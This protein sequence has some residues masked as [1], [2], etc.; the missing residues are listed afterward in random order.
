MIRRPPRSTQGVSSA[1]SDVYKRQQLA[2][3]GYDVEVRFLVDT[4]ID[5]AVSFKKRWGFKEAEIVTDHREI[6]GKVDAALIFTPHAFH[7]GQCLDFL[8]SEAHVLVEKPMVC[9]LEHAY[10]LVE[11]SKSKGLVLEVGYQRHFE[12]PFIGLRETLLKEELGKVNIISMILG[13]DWYLGTK[14]T[15]RQVRDCLLY[16]SPSPRDG[17]LSRMPSS[18]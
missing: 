12:P 7:Y 11:E 15:W 3:H 14:G 8:N 13:Q 16:T 1:A 4:R 2:E 9:R 18:A 17:L 10:H 5:A 6:L